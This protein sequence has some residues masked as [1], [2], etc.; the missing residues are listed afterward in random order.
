MAKSKEA[1]ITDLVHQG[2]IR[3][4]AET[5]LAPRIVTRVV[6]AVTDTAI[7]WTA[8]VGAATGSALETAVVTPSGSLPRVGMLIGAGV[9]SL[10]SAL[11]R[12]G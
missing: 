6:S 11:S 12:T 2:V 8:I 3:T 10:I 5:P 1:L 7:V 4:A 9:G